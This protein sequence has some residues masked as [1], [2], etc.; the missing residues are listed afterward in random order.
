[1]A[2]GIAPSFFQLGILI[3]VFGIVIL[4][5]KQFLVVEVPIGDIKMALHNP[6]FQGS[7]VNPTYGPG[8]YCTGATL[9]TSYDYPQ[10]LPCQYLD[11]SQ[12]QTANVAG[13]IFLTSH[14]NDT[15]FQ[16]NCSHFEPNCT[17]VGIGNLDYFI[18]NLENYVISIDHSPRAPT[19]GIALTGGIS[20]EL[21]TA[22]N[23]A[24]TSWKTFEKLGTSLYADQFTLN[25]FFQAAK[26]DLQNEGNAYLDPPQLESSRY[27]GVIILMMLN[28]DNINNYYSNKEA[29]YY[30]YRPVVL[31]AMSDSESSSYPINFPTTR[32]QRNS[33]GV[34]IVGVI[35]GTLGAFQ[36]Q[37]LL[38][39]LTTGLALVKLATVVVDFLATKLMPQRNIYANIKFE[40][41]QTFTDIRKAIKKTTAHNTV[42]LGVTR[43]PHLPGDSHKDNS[44][45]IGDDS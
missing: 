18:G 17:E 13:S 42:E 28:Y 32:L 1:L 10:V 15:V 6:G 30:T 45:S 26:L 22:A 31:G 23:S 27:F 29:I 12:I 37:Q 41:T 25:T 33:N 4:Y 40:K 20:G 38:V 14:S 8:V 7:E 21:Q 44:V 2:V 36:F 24:A 35:T 43:S 39:Q 9:N 11:A 3:Y 34:R 5:Y 19:L 16:A